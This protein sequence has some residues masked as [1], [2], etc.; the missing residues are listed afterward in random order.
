MTS[1]R[2]AL[3]DEPVDRRS[4]GRRRHELSDLG[5]SV[6]DDEGLASPRKRA[7]LPAKSLRYSASSWVTGNQSGRWREK[8]CGSLKYVMKTS[9]CLPR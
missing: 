8:K 5:S 2:A 1:S 6:G 4:P 9:G 3:G 7:R